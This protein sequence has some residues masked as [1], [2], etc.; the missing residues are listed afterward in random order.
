MS[1][2][3]K[4]VQDCTDAG[5]TPTYTGSL[6]TE[7]TYLVN[8]DGKT[9]LHFK[10]SGAGA[11]TVT[12]QTPKTV[13]GLAIAERTFVV[14]ATTGDIV[15]GFFPPNIYNNADHNLIFSCSEVTGLT[16]AAVRF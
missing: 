1:E 5:I 6:S 9:M 4:A 12:V 8:N 16:V 15:T 10:K 14:A 11:C 3:T 2:V 13:K 7:N